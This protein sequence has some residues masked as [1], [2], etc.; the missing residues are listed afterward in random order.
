MPK[1]ISYNTIQ[2]IVRRQRLRLSRKE[3]KIIKESK[4]FF[5]GKDPKEY[6]GEG[7]DLREIN[8][9]HQKDFA[10]TIIDL[11][12]KFPGETIRV[13]NEGAGSSTF[14]G[15]LEKELKD[16]VKMQIITTDIQRAHKPDVIAVPE[17]LAKIFGINSFHLVESTHGGIYHTKLYPPKKAIANVIEILKPGGIASLKI[18]MDQKIESDLGTFLARYKNIDWKISDDLAFK[19][20]TIKKRTG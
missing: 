8:H 20:L 9:L 7:R 3:R 11:S 14:K 5:D 4:R 13:L 15:D 6:L 1:R 18:I 17:E 16:T 12:R 10:K 19:T 2:S